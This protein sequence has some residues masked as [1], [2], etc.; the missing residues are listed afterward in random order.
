MNLLQQFPVAVLRGFAQVMLQN[1]PFTGVLFFMGIMATSLDMAL[2]A[3]LGNLAGA[4]TAILLNRDKSEIIEGKYGFNGVLVA[5]AIYVFYGALWSQSITLFL[6]VIIVTSAL[7]TSVMMAFSR[8]TK[9]A[10]FTMPFVI[11]TWLAM[12]L[13]DT[14]GWAGDVATMQLPMLPPF[15]PESAFLASFGVTINESTGPFLQYAATILRGVG[16]VMFQESLVTGLIFLVALSRSSNRV[17]AYA[18]LGAGLGGAIAISGGIAPADVHHGLY[19]FNAVLTAIAL[20]SV[21]KEKIHFT[22]MG[23][24]ISVLVTWAFVMLQWPSLTAPFVLATW[25]IIL[26]D[27]QMKIQR[28]KRAVN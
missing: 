4:V 28:Q 12:L 25:F 8:W 13:I 2:L 9:L 17:T 1:N 16:Q 7:S 11:S 19:G 22:L 14:L 10:A 5:I 18:I 21:M 3:L 27:Q 26:V 24:G 20:A 15:I 23:V 6:S